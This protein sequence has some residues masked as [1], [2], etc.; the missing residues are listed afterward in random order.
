LHEASAQSRLDL[1]K[2]CYVLFSEDPIFGCGPDH[3]PLHAESFGWEPLKEAHSLWVQT[4]TE[5]GIPGIIMYSG[6][7]LS[8]I[9]GCWKMLKILPPDADP[10]FGDSCR[11]TIAAL[12]GFGVSAQF[13]SLEALEVPYYT[14]LLGAGGIMIYGRVREQCPVAEELLPARTSDWRDETHSEVLNQPGFGFGD[15]Q[16]T[17]LN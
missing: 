3:W 1:W 5:T 13:V 15:G 12:V 9:I 17:I 4:A 7:Y 16:V 8:C 10:W 6:F 14:A 2:D 11:M